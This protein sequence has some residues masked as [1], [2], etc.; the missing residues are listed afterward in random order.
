[1][2]QSKTT[3]GARPWWR[4]SAGNKNRQ[5]PRRKEWG[6]AG[7]VQVTFFSTSAVQE[8]LW[9]TRFSSQLSIPPGTYLWKWVVPPIL[10]PDRVFGA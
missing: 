2:S 6:F 7:H 1:M 8:T 9:E 10:A 3:S 5:G 4:P